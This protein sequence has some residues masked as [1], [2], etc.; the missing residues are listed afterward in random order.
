V[1]ER[2]V[3]S[4]LDRCTVS[5]SLDDEDSASAEGQDDRARRKNKS[6]DAEQKEDRSDKGDRVFREKAA[7]SKEMP[8]KHPAKTKKDN[9]LVLIRRNETEPHHSL[10]TKLGFDRRTKRV[11]QS[12]EMQVKAFSKLSPEKG[13]SPFAS[14]SPAKKD[15]AQNIFA[16][17]MKRS[18]AL[19]SKS[20]NVAR[21]RFHLHNIDGFVTWTSEDDEEN[22]SECK[23]TSGGRANGE[24]I[25][26]GDSDRDDLKQSTSHGASIPKKKHSFLSSF[27]DGNLQWSAT[28]TIKKPQ[29]V[30]CQ[31]AA[32]HIEEYALDGP[33]ERRYDKPDKS[34]EL[35]ISSS[36]PFPQEGLTRHRLVRVHSRLSV[37]HLKSCL[38]KSIRRR[39]PL[40]AVRV[41][42]ELAD[43][44]WGDL[45]RR[46]PII[47]L[48]D[49]TL[50]PD[51]P[52]LVW[53][54]VA[55]SK[56]Y[57]PPMPLVVRV[58]QIVFEIAACPRQDD[59]MSTEFLDKTSC[60]AQELPELFSLSSPP[61]SLFPKQCL[62]ISTCETFVR[63]I[64]LRAQYGGMPCDVKMLQ[65]FSITW[66]K[67]FRVQSVPLN[68]L[69]Q[70]PE[71][72]EENIATDESKTEL[73]SEVTSWQHYP[74][75]IH[76]KARDQ[77]QHLVTSK[78]VSPFGLNKLN[79][80]DV[81]TA[82]IDFHCS[83]VVDVL[84][85]NPNLVISLR[86]KFSGKKDIKDK[87]DRDWLS[88]Q[89]KCCIWECSSGV[90]H[91]LPIVPQVENDNEV[92]MQS[93]WDNIIK[94]P[95]NRFTKSFVNKRLSF[96]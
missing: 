12:I 82:G 83:S 74:K 18:A 19:F 63:S 56:N 33:T 93:V 37:A 70:L 4:H 71:I 13:N 94:E 43:K 24:S 50:H 26:I 54:M 96:Q 90:N 72:S 40:P 29:I 21:Q 61:S 1:T 11:N 49:S 78:L 17:M 20:E 10:G 41:A 22:F 75:L 48:E 88:R 64:L 47:V 55:D 2:D 38:Q 8:H 42:M 28:I 46:L 73:K 76:K 89:I 65:K 34:L 3:N 62:A 16:H 5:M 9:P 53:L 84:L 45:I 86:E 68:I 25:C 44:S 66:L 95:F 57:I 36:I 39:A 59:A 31:S 30:S 67:R 7:K 58:M 80:N 69:S 52:L 35:T 27:S 91:R 87:I 15:G 60:E 85:S 79:M 32:Q 92:M 81:C 77:S 6:K 51:F 23:P 14:T